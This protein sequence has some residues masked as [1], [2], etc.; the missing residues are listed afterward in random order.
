MDSMYH[1]IVA[2]H[3]LFKLF[4]PISNTGCLHLSFNSSRTYTIKNK[5]K[6]QK[7]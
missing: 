2:I 7:P 4:S 6:I 5:Y 3:T 1:R